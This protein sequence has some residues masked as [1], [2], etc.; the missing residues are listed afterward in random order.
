MK[1]ERVR[2]LI[3]GIPFASPERGRELYDF[4]AESEPKRCLELGFAHGVSTCYIAA[5]LEKLGQG[6]LD[7]VDLENQAWQKP[8][9][10]E[11]LSK[12]GLSHRV[13]IY[14]EKTSYNW[15]LKKSIEKLSVGSSCQPIYDFCVIDG[16]KNW[17]IDGFAF[18]L[19]DKLLKE[20]G[21]I[22]FDDYSYA[23]G[24]ERSVTDGI[25]H[26]ELGLDELTEPHI[27]AIFHLLITQHP[28]YG[29]FEVVNEQWAWA[30]KIRGTER[31]LIPKEHLGL[32]EKSARAMRRLRRSL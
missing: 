30:F 18:F 31:V 29:R 2:D 9:V 20:G 32:W 16:P 22:L 24:T 23:Y 8:S 6:H 27:K 13:T 3:H 19:V 14:R 12:C 4:I 11:L 5:A 7:C 1:F 10:E 25:N 15:F 26:Q 21:A 17:T 28:S